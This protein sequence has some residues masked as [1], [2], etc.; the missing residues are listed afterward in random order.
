[1][2]V[3]YHPYTTKAEGSDADARDFVKRVV[4]AHQWLRSAGVKQIWATEWGWSS[5]KGPVEEQPIVGEDG[6]ADFTL[7]RLALMAALDYDKVFLFTLSDLDSRASERDQHYGLLR[8]NGEPKPVFHALKRF[9]QVCGPRLEP[10]T[11]PAVE[12]LKGDAPEGLVS[13]GWRRPDGARLWMA[14]AEKK[15]EV[16]IPA[17]GKSAV[18][19]HPVSG[20][21]TTLESSQGKLRLTLEPG[22][23]ILVQAVGPAVGKS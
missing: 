15:A 17:Q 7:K 1:M 18:L 21:Q 5:Y 2:T 3:A 22:L 23:Q 10:D 11:P 8:L 4:P 9:L 19:H 6:Q 12:A 16:R 13:I 20:R 14:W